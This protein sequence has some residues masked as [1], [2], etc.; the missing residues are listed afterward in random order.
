MQ[1]Y[2]IIG[3]GNIGEAYTHTRHNI[4]FQVV[5]AWAQALGISFSAQRLGQMA[6]GSYKGRKVYLLKPD[7]YMNLSGKSIKFWMEKY[8]I[9]SEQ[10]LV[11]T[12]DLHLPFGTLR[13]KSK[14]SDGG[15]NGLKSIQNELQTIQYPRMRLGI[16]K[17]TFNQVDYV[18]G[19][20]TEDEKK[21]LDKIL[22]S[23]M[24]ALQSFVFN[25]TAHT[26]NHFNKSF[27]IEN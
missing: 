2:L 18:L 5:D 7:T 25:G 13:I 24:L 1:K 6:E 11:I 14:G 3:L 17:P 8:S 21:N 27:M 20:W 19:Q 12:D 4:G 22:P 10:I 15:H 26:M 23:C 16:G 9:E